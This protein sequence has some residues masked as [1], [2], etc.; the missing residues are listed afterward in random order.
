MV[1][2]QNIIVGFIGTYTKNKS[3][4]IYKFNFD[5]TSGNIEKYNLA[6]EIENPT[7]L[8]IDKE[9]H[10]LYSTCKVAEKSGVSSFKYWEEDDR[11]HLINSNLSEEKPPCHVSLN[12]NSEILIS[13]N[14]HENKML[15]YKTLDGL[16][17][18][19]PILGNHS[20]SSINLSR[21]K[22]PHIHCS[23]FTHDE[24]YI[25]SIDLGIDKMIVSTLENGKLLQ[26]E[27]L[28]FN[29]PGGTGPR[30]IT[31]TNKNPY[32]YYVLSELTSEIFVFSYNSKSEVTFENTQ[33]LSSLPQN[34]KGEKSGAAIHIHKNNKFLYT[35]DRGNNSLSLFH[36]NP[37]NGK[38]K[39]IDTFSCNGNSP[40]D[41][42]LDPTG[43]FLLCSN[44]NSDN[45]SV[46]SINPT[47]GTLTFVNSWNIPTP[48]CIEFA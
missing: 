31:Y 22:K 10:I 7:Y 43:K 5:I 11:L 21:Q 13:S 30:H 17:L 41:F 19:S 33:T 46:F 47:I 37:N 3:N 29:F 40:R 26:N 34:Y 12:A 16:I 39:Y 28:S 35:S 23:M 1:L 36:I 2:K 20:G 45:I 8:T 14:Y 48:T 15:V 6:Y 4:G 42:Q 27:K 9:R 32:Y 38:L 25:L 24:K 18:S 44:E